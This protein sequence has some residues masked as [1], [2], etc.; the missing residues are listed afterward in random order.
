M[1][2]GRTGKD[3]MKLLRRTV[4]WSELQNSERLSSGALAA[5]Y[6]AMNRGRTG[7]DAMKMLQ[8]TAIS[9]IIGT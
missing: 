8:R 1:N 6:Y 5:M 4:I 2:R 7:K 3:T 9:F